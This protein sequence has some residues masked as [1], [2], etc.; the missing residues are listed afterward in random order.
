MGKQR[1]MNDWRSAP[2]HKAS[3]RPRLAFFRLNRTDLPIFVQQHFDEHVRCLEFFFDVF[4]IEENCSYDEVCDRLQVDLAL[5]ESGAYTRAN[6]HISD[7]HRHPAVPK[8]GLLNAD[9]YCLTR[10]LFLSDMDQWGVESFFTI[11][12]SLPNRVPHL[13][14]RLFVWP[15]FADTRRFRTYPCEKKTPILF[16][17]SRATNYPWRNRMNHLLRRRFPVAALPHGGWFDASKTRNVLSGESYARALSSSLIVPTC[18]TIAHD[19]VRK[20]LEVP[21]CGALLL[22]ERTAAVEAAGFVDM[23]TCVFADETDVVDKVGHLLAH[24]EEIERI[25]RAGQ[26]LVHTRHDIALRNQIFQWFDLTKRSAP[27]EI[28]TQTDPFGDMVLRPTGIGSCRAPEVI[29]G[30]DW[31]LTD[32]ADKASAAGLFDSARAGYHAVLNYHYEAEAAVG[33][34]RTSLRCGDA[35]RAREWVWDS[36]VHCMRHGATQPDPVEWSVYILTLL[37]AGDVRSAIRMA[38]HYGLLTH[39]ELA[40]VR[41]L[42]HRLAGTSLPVVSG[43]YRYSI[44]RDRNLSWVAWVEDVARMLE[45]CGQVNMAQRALA[46][47]RDPEPSLDLSCSRGREE[48]RSVGRQLSKLKYFPL[49]HRVRSR[50]AQLYHGRGRATQNPFPDILA[51]RGIRTMML[52]G[53]SSEDIVGQF[54]RNACRRSP[55]PCTLIMVGDPLGSN[56]SP[57][58]V[59]GRGSNALGDGG[60]LRIALPDRCGIIIGPP[61]ADLLTLDVCL[62]AELIILTNVDEK[63][64]PS[65]A[66]GLDTA[67]SCKR[68]TLPAPAGEF[69]LVAW[70]AST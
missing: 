41:H 21:A 36:M 43:R 48:P 47:A 46:V 50:L 58:R 25:S 49:Y 30:Q 40:R 53:L 57:S 51:G 70:E 13:R 60:P 33:M 17:G 55:E 5:F 38:R 54:A 19:L 16:A 65:L 34:A 39:V 7:T 2:P 18:G 28:V 67:S 22:A 59:L 29:V 15:N 14:D 68:L 42:L 27:G 66:A 8:A 26:Q 10:S 31:A 9:A 45:T 56:S 52:V 24:P 11:S 3:G 32:A 44:H 63:S 61:A 12:M 20:H 23:E 35:A 69:G 6:H 37:C 1:A 4:L 62:S 64:L